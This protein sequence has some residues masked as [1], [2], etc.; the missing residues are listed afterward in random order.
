MACGP[1][2]AMRYKVQVTR[3]LHSGFFVANRCAEHTRLL[4]A[5][6]ICPGND[7]IV[8]YLALS[9]FE[10]LDASRDSVRAPKNM[11]IV[12]ML[13]INC[14]PVNQPFRDRRFFVNVVDRNG[15]L[16]TMRA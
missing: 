1:K 7:E 12:V 10:L 2:H 5:V 4:R 14:C 11:D 15:R 3:V 8:C 9:F 6:M 13:L 16:R